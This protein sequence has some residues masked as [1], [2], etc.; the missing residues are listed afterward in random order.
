MKTRSETPAGVHY[1]ELIA[2]LF[3]FPHLLFDCVLPIPTVHVCHLP[4]RM[5]EVVMVRLSVSYP[6][7]TAITQKWQVL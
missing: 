5:R 4:S 3:L 7:Q 6:L 2:R 1:I